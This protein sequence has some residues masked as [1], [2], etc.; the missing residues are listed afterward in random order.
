MADA[1]ST[2]KSSDLTDS[3]HDSGS[4]NSA[5]GSETPT[6]P[7]DGRSGKVLKRTDWLAFWLTFLVTM[8]VYTLTLNPTVSLEDSGELAVAAD[9]LGVPHPPG[10]P[11]WT[12]TAWFF[13]WVFD[14]VEYNGHPNPAWGVALMSAFFGALACALLGMLISCSGRH[15]VSSL[16]T[17][18]FSLAKEHLPMGA[19]AILGFGL[20][21]ILNVSA[22]PSA[23]FAILLFIAA[24]YI[25]GSFTANYFFDREDV[26]PLVPT[27]YLG[28]GLFGSLFGVMLYFG[29]AMSN[30]IAIGVILTLIVSTVIGSIVLYHA[31]QKTPKLPENLTNLLTLIFGVAGGLLLAFSPVMWSQS[32]I[33]EVYSLN[34]F[35]MAFI[36]LTTYIWACQPKRAMLLYL[37]AFLFGLGLTNHQSLLFIMPLLLAVIAYRDKK[38]FTASLCIILIGIA[39]LS[40]F[41]H[42]QYID[43]A[44]LVMSD[45]KSNSPQA[46][47]QKAQESAAADR[48]SAKFFTVIAIIFALLPAGLLL[49]RREITSLITLAA[50]FFGILFLGFGL[51]ADDTTSTA[52]KVMLML[53]GAG[54]LG[55]PF[56]YL[57]KGD[58]NFTPWMRNY[59]IAASIFAGLL[60]HG[61]MAISSEQNPPMNW[62]YPRTPQGFEHALSRG[63]YEKISI[64][65]NWDRIVAQ[66]N[67][68]RKAPPE[69]TG[70]ETPEQLAAFEQNAILEQENY[71]K[72]KFRIFRQ[73]AVYFYNPR[74][75]YSVDKYSMVNIFTIPLSI[76]ALLP[77]SLLFRLGDRTR[78]WFISMVWTMFFLT[79]VFLIAQFPNLDVQDLFIKR[80]QYIQAHGVFAIWIAYGSLLLTVT[81]YKLVPVKPLA[82]G[83]AAVLGSIIAGLGIHKEFKDELHIETVGAARM[84]DHDFGWQFGYYQLK[85]ANGLI[86]DYLNEND[87]HE[88]R[89]DDEAL[90]FLNDRMD[91]R[92]YVER[93]DEVK[94][95]IDQVTTFKTDGETDKKT[96]TK[97][98]LKGIKGKERNYVIQAA[99]L[100]AYKHKRAQPGYQVSEEEVPNVNYPPPMEKDGVFFG[101]TDPGR[102]VPT[103]MIYSAKVRPDV[104]LITQNALADGT[105]M[106]VM[107]DLYGDD[108]WI[109]SA[110]DS[111]TAFS[112]Y[113]AKVQAGEI[114]AGADL[115]FEGGKVSVQG[116]GGVMAINAILCKDIHDHNLHSNSFYV[117]ESYPIPWMFEYLTPHGLIMKINPHPTKISEQLIEDDF[118]FWN[119]YTQRLQNDPAFMDDAIARKTFSKLRSS[120]AG[121]YASK[122][123]DAQAELAYQQAL[124]LYPLSP[125][126]TFK[127]AEFYIKRQRVED[128]EDAITRL[129]K[130]DIE[131]DKIAQFQR[132]LGPLKQ[133]NE[134]RITLESQLIKGGKQDINVAFQLLGVYQSMGMNREI[135]EMVNSI[136]ANPSSNPQIH[137]QLAEGML[138]LKQNKLAKEVYDQ[139]LAK[140]PNDYRVHV[141]IAAMNLRQQKPSDCLQSLKAA[142]KIGKDAAKKLIIAEPTFEGIR[143]TQDYVALIYPE[144]YKQMQ[145]QQKQ[146]RQPGTRPGT[147]PGGSGV[148]LPSSILP[149]GQR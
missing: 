73:F 130:R 54:C 106:N 78:T 5:Q 88:Y 46:A 114:K 99:R 59:F 55:G 146:Q 45:L 110:R 76:I 23:A 43:S 70:R 38:M 134:R 57:V 72:T 141:R 144:K 16:K 112:R 86:L 66:L 87:I 83:V 81:L 90:A 149:P 124:E 26:L 129:M 103:Y 61:Y 9:Y 29:A 15:M 119:W 2:N 49:A 80:V 85:G 136:M 62:G 148:R 127:M 140:N 21:A 17:E 143:N 50:M 95:I 100:S 131:N 105:Y 3:K 40:I 52:A 121:L 118:T 19:G 48:D 8:V 93:K 1:A 109:P 4:A 14:F 92:L 145:E 126:A 125:E 7:Q 27:R 79:V 10:Y 32:V 91:G 94:E 132:S 147:L 47:I 84:N 77:F 53:V 31:Q 63:Q 51:T 123:N 97:K 96:F 12:L 69:L 135:R 74:N 111:N 20:T 137:L 28:S 142:V 64:K 33:V 89:I 117:E 65:A 122:G 30:V 13:Q 6:L 120:L 71:K 116:V 133:V 82:L 11:I 36:I 128:A 58:H 39:I 24:I 107:R 56:V 35:F 41:K 113:I 139:I 68:E 115:N 18:R 44:E 102:F 25:V 34:V 108:M 75:E 101:G 67:M 98:V 37:T 22:L 60:F 138:R 42:H 104:Y